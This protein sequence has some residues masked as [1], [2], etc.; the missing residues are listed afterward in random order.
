MKDAFSNEAQILRISVW[1]T[2]KHVLDED[3]TLSDVLVDDELL[4]IGS[5]EENHFQSIIV[6]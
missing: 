1:F 6:F 5:Y 2:F 3:A 4:V